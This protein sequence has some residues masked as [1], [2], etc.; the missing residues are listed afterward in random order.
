MKVMIAV[1]IGGL[2]HS[3]G[4]SVVLHNSSCPLQSW[5]SCTCF[6]GTIKAA[7]QSYGCKWGWITK[8]VNLSVNE[9]NSQSKNIL[10]S[11]QE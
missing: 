11:L 3:S 1:A 4:T 5:V 7:Q 8:Y 2:H 10:K 9:T 6:G